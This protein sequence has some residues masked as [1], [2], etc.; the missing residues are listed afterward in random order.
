VQ[1]VLGEEGEPVDTLLLVVSELGLDRDGDLVPLDLAAVE[2]L[3]E[4]LTLARP[5]GKQLVWEAWWVGDA[6]LSGYD[7]VSVSMTPSIGRRPGL[8]CLLPAAPS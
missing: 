6:G 4:E 7:D 8:A 3:V 2:Q 5:L 1:L